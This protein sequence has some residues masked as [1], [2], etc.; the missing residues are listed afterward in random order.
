[1]NEGELFAI[2]PRL[3]HLSAG[4]AWPSIRVH[5]LLSTSGLLD[6]YEIHGAARVPFESTRRDATIALSRSGYPDVL[7]RDQT[8]M[9][10]RAL[11]ACLLNGMTPA[12]WYHTLNGMV[13]FFASRRKLEKLQNAKAGRNLAQLVLTVDTRSL[14]SAYRDRILLSGM[15]TGATFRR[16]LP[17]GP[18]TFLPIADF[19]YQERRKTRAPADALVE[20]TVAGGIP[21]VVN[22]LIAVEEVAPGR[23]THIWPPPNNSIHTMPA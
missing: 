10:D 11:A 8:P 14:V 22:Y 17:R 21:D 12:E 6:L 7:L 1:V 15:N 5:G 2:F 4:P 3:Y 23:R 13:F 9:T 19:P 18:R 20:V 16:A